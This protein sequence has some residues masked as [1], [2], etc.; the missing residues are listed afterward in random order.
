[1]ANFLDY[2][3]GLT[4]P[5]AR[6]GQNQLV[7]AHTSTAYGLTWIFAEAKAQVITFPKGAIIGRI[8]QTATVL[9]KTTKKVIAYTAVDLQEPILVDKIKRKY[10]SYLWFKPSELAIVENILPVPNSKTL[11]VLY[12]STPSGVKLRVEPNTLKKPL[13]VIAFGDVIGFTDKT[14]Q[15]YLGISFFK[16]V[17]AQAKTLGWVAS[18][19]TSFEKPQAKALPDINAQG[20]ASSAII[21]QQDD[22]QAFKDVSS[23]GFVK[24]LLYALASMLLAW[25]GYRFVKNARK[26]T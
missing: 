10:I 11:H 4:T 23:T 18:E 2:L 22:P 1:M 24:V 12:A 19:Y 21:T 3:Q 14:S 8:K 17:D 20:E 6:A 15:S 5:D 26:N 7:K 9:D 16:V 13:K 25:I